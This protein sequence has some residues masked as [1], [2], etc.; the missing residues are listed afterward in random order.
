MDM[1]GTMGGQQPEPSRFTQGVPIGPQ[2]PAHPHLH[3]RKPRRHPLRK[4][5]GLLRRKQA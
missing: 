1:M 4:L 2:P 5:A 3:P